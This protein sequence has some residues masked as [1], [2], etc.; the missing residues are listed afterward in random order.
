MSVTQAWPFRTAVARFIIPMAL[1]AIAIPNVGADPVGIPTEKRQGSCSDFNTFLQ[2]KGVKPRSNDDESKRVPKRAGVTYAEIKNSPNINE[3][4]RPD[5]QWCYKV[6]LA[7]YP[8]EV[9]AQSRILKWTPAEK[10]SKECSAHLDAWLSN[11]AAHEQHHVEDIK[12]YTDAQW[13]AW[14]A[15][16]FEKCGPQAAT[17]TLVTEEANAFLEKGRDEIAGKIRSMAE[18]FHQ[19]EAGKPTPPLNCNICDSSSRPTK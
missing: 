13:K 5:G 6:D 7:T 19:T 16:V 17:R 18:E 2:E 3:T 1:C 9:T 12:R 15:R 11:V 8:F 10:P 4:E 14:K